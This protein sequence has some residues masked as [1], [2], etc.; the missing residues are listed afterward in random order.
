MGED[1]PWQTLYTRS[2]RAMYLSH[3]VRRKICGTPTSI[4]RITHKTLKLCYDAFYRPDN[5]YLIVCG[6]MDMARVIA[7]VDEPLT[8]WANRTASRPVAH[9]IP[10]KEPPRL[11]R[12]KTTGH[13]N[14]SQPLFRICWKD[15]TYMPDAASRVRREIGMSILSEMLFCRAGASTTSCLRPARF[16]P[17]IPMNAQRSTATARLPITLLW[18]RRTILPLSLTS[19]AII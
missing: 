1:D 7:A 4:G 5:M 16:R 10:V 17:P 3:G 8:A 13:G 6:D 15:T 18:A 9:P 2:M 19:I 11:L 14:V 12:R